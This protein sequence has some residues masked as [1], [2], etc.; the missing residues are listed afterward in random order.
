LPSLG[1]ASCLRHGS[2][3]R[4]FS[5]AFTLAKINAEKLFYLKQ[6]LD[7]LIK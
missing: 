1:P 2:R 3:P 4:R 6:E 7:R 5:P